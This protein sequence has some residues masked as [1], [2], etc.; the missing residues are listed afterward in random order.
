MCIAR[1]KK[2]LNTF[3]AIFGQMLECGF[4]RTFVIVGLRYTVKS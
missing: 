3:I 1:N 2:P 4:V